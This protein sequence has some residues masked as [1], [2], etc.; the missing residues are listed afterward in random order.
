MI[1]VE[2]CLLKD[3]ISKRII[4]NLSMIYAIDL[5]IHYFRD[6]AKLQ[7]NII[8]IIVSTIILQSANDTCK[9]WSG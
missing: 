7:K 3:D 5:M 2:I 9:I 4:I 8:N 1:F 6:Y